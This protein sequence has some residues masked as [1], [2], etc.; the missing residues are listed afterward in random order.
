MLLAG[1]IDA[2][3]IGLQKYVLTKFIISFASSRNEW[4][5]Y[6]EF[7]GEMVGKRVNYPEI[8]TLNS[9][10]T[11]ITTPATSLH[12]YRMKLRV[13]TFIFPK[14]GSYSSSQIM[15]GKSNCDN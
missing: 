1:F 7:N 12:C 15:A 2:P 8:T 14:N 6:T 10:V 9:T 5:N 11:P 4:N 13:S 3:V